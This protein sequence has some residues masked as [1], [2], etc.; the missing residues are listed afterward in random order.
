MHTQR[1]PGKVKTFQ[2]FHTALAHAAAEQQKFFCLSQQCPPG[3]PSLKPGDLHDEILHLSPEKTTLPPLVILGP[4][5]PLSGF[6]AF[7]KVC[8]NYRNSREII[9]IRLGDAPKHTEAIEEAT[10][11]GVKL[12]RH[13]RRLVCAIESAIL[14]AAMLATERSS[15]WELMILNHAVHFFLPEVR[16]NLARKNFPGQEGMKILSMIDTAATKSRQSD[17]K[18]LVLSSHGSRKSAVY[19]NRLKE[20]R[21]NFHALDPLLQE[22]LDTILDR[23]VRRLDIRYILEHG[24]KLI[25]KIIEKYPRVNTIITGDNE[26]PWLFDLVKIKGETKYRKYFNRTRL[27]DPAGASLGLQAL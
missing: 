14:C 18:V 3:A 23:G 10:N 21:R 1:H 19:E 27:I 6:D 9:L 15:S 24:T 11:P 20:S 22:K 13:K 16:Q 17:Q 25:D 2:K 12:S 4:V 26:I 7:E 8:H 5:G